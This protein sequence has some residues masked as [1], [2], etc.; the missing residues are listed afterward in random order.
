MAFA[1]A[2]SACCPLGTMAGL[3]R[4]AVHGLPGGHGLLVQDGIPREDQNAPCSWVL[5]TVQCD[6]LYT[7]GSS[8]LCCG[9]VEA[10]HHHSRCY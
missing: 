9:L 10:T 1:G 7:C 8:E 4:Q 3:W 6:V 5:D 2:C